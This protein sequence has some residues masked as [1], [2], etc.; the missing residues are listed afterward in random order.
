[1]R[2]RSR[3]AASGAGGAAAQGAGATGRGGPAA[4]REDRAAGAEDAA[5]AGP[6]DVGDQDP[7]RIDGPPVSVRGIVLRDDRPVTGAAVTIHRSHPTNRPAYW[8]WRRRSD[9]APRPPIARTKTDPRGRFSLRFARR[10]RFTLDVHATGSG[11]VR[12]LVRGP[13]EGDPGEVTIR[14]ESGFTLRGKVSTVDGKPVAGAAV[15]GS[16]AASAASTPVGRR[17]TVTDDRGEFALDDLPE[18]GVSVTVTAEG[19]ASATTS[20]SLPRTRHLP[21]VL[22]KGG[23]IFGTIRDDAGK[24]VPGA[25]ITFT[26]RVGDG[27]SG[28]SGADADDQGSYRAEGLAPGPVTQV[29]VAAEGYPVESSWRGELL[30]PAQTLASGGE[31]QYDVVLR[32]GTKVTGTVVRAT[33][34]GAVGGALVKLARQQGQQL[35]DIASVESGAGGRFTFEHVPPGSYG[36]EASAPGWGSRPLVRWPQGNKPLTLDFSIVEGGPAPDPRRLELEPRGTVLGQVVGLERQDRQRV[37][38]NVQVAESYFSGPVD[39][40]GAFLIERVPPTD[41][42]VAR[43]W[44]PP[45][46]SEPF[47]VAAGEIA[48]VTLDLADAG[49]FTGVVV[50]GE[51]RPVRGAYVKADPVQ[52]LGNNLQQASNLLNNS[53]GAA[54][55]DAEGRFRLGVQKWQRDNLATADWAVYAAHPDYALALR[56][57][58]SLPGKGDSVEVRLVME[59]GQRVAGQVKWADGRPVPN[60]SV[61]LS[62]KRDPQS[63]PRP[64][65]VVEGVANRAARLR[66][67]ARTDAEGR[68]DSR[69]VEPG[70]YLVSASTADGKTRSEEV[71]AGATDLRLEMQATAHIGGLVVDDLGKPVPRAQVT[72]LIPEGKTIRRASATTGTGG[73]F[74][75]SQLEP[76]TYTL[77]VAPRRQQWYGQGVVRFTKKTVDG[78]ATGTDDLIVRVEPGAK[79]RGRVLGPGGQPVKGAG[80]VAMPQK[81]DPKRRRQSWNVARPTTVTDADGNFELR[82][83]G[84]EPVELLA[85]AH[86][87]VPAAMPASAGQQGVVIRLEEGAEIRGRLLDVRGKPVSGQWLWLQPLTPEVAQRSGDWPPRGG[88]AYYSFGRRSNAQTDSRGKFRFAGLFEG[89]YQLNG[90]PPGGVLPLVKVRTGERSLVVRLEEPLSVSGRIVDSDGNPVGPAAGRNVWINARQGTR[91]LR[92]VQAKADGTFELRN[93]PAGTVTLQAWAYPAYNQASVDVVAGSTGVVITLTKRTPPPTPPQRAGR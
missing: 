45:A 23:A 56:K 12:T 57:G 10:T 90:Q 64:V 8:W 20:G 30:L 61:S 55:T 77:E 40:V 13:P 83:V 11:Q 67:R 33:D 7:N 54:R 86:G 22:R 74:Q 2:G 70:P 65:V 78:V 66:R 48:E 88:Q 27:T 38:V 28:S 62:P 24:P 81:L 93:L 18:G 63:K 72:A 87:L 5:A 21:V 75:V 29:T 59:P 39:G 41:S 35:Q 37:S 85:A 82:G 49:G 76:G 47:P 32:S 84:E 31:L 43:L 68:V 26:T 6:L 14:L 71:E 80:V 79:I 69:G 17:D 25:R 44:S 92:G 19:Y 16:V 4:G 46:E 89:E 60:A 3:R 50:D 91:W 73:R 53:W 36:V 51:D 34:G 9:D 1:G 58:L 52:N 42:A 15:R